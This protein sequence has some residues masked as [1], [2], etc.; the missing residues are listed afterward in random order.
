MAE[1]LAILHEV[2]SGFLQSLQDIVGIVQGVR[3]GTVV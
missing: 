2:Y 3:G 1:T